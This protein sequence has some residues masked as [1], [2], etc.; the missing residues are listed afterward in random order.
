MVGKNRWRW[1]L[2]AAQ[3]TE[4]QKIVVDSDDGNDVQEYLLQDAN[5]SFHKFKEF[6]KTK[7]CCFKVINY[8]S[9]MYINTG[10]SL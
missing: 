6:S 1:T 2:Y 4:G 7:R 3:F 5:D 9:N 8:K 10:T